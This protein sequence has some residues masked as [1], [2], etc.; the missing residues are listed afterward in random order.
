MARSEGSGRATDADDEVVVGSFT[1]NKR[2]QVKVTLSKYMGYD[3]VGVRVWFK[4]D[5]GS[6]KPGKSGINIRT[7]LL[8]ELMRLL[9]RAHDEAK[10]RGLLDGPTSNAPSDEG[11]QT[12]G[13]RRIIDLIDEEPDASR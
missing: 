5:D 13:L 11:S 3:L 4:S 9:D 6:Y 1:K 7:S 2:E 8:P 10:K 12:D